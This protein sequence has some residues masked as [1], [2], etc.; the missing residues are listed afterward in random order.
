M[1]RGY[2]LTGTDTGVGKTLIASAL[3]HAAAGQGL[4][5][6]GMKPVAAGELIPAASP[7]RG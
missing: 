2:F 4:R 3:L 1:S 7:G 6:L 5:A